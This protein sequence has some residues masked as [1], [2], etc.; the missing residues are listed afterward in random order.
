MK[1][2]ITSLVWSYDEYATRYAAFTGVQHPRVE[3]IEGLRDMVKRAIIA[4]GMRNRASPKRIVFFRDGVSE[5]EF[6]QVLKIELGAM[7]A[8][9]DEVW[10]ERK[11]IKDPKPKVT[12]IVV[13]K[14]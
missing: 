3:T 10:T 4:F 8:A 9:F 13:G 2:S 14:R 1:P 5:G 6:D 12:F 11:I 7:R